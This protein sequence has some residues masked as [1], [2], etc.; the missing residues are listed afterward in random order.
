MTAIEAEANSAATRVSQPKFDSELVLVCAIS[1]LFTL[2]I[3]IAAHPPMADYPQ[4]LSMA[5]VLR[6][7]HDPARHLAETYTL[8][9]TRPNTAFAFLVVALSYL[10]PI[11]IA[12]KLVMAFSVAATGMAGLALARRAG[13]PGWFGLFALI[14]AYNC[15]YFFGFVNNVTATPL[16]LL[17]VVV[18]DRQLDRPI[19]WRSWLVLA[20]Y[21]C[22][23][24][25]VHLQFLFLFV[26]TVGWLTLTRRRDWRSWVWISSSQ[27]ATVTMTLLYYFLSHP[28]T[29]GYHEK[30]IY[31]DT[32]ASPLIF[33]KL[34]QI[35]EY[36]FGALADSKHW[37]LFGIAVLAVCLVVR[38]RLQAT[39]A[40]EEPTEQGRWKATTISLERSRFLS[41]SIWFFVAYLVMPHV[42]VGVFVYQRLIAVAWMML[43][44]V[45]PFPDPRKLGA[46]KLVLAGT[47]VLHMVINIDAA[48]IFQAE[49]R[50]GHAL[51]AKTSPGKN[52][53]AV[54][55]WM[56]SAGIQSPPLFVHFG[57]HYLA[58]KGGRVFFSF[59]ELY[60]SSVQLRPE[61]AFDDQDASMNEWQPLQFRFAD[62][63]YH[64]DYFLCHGNFD[65]LIPIFGRHIADLA[66]EAQDDWI[67]LWR[68]SQTDLGH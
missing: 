58:E 6:W 51:I 63:G 55:M 3:W 4:H 34:I 28:E 23:F 50:G 44:A 57:S 15:G 53:M 19:G 46:S 52:L 29:F 66:W 59:S 22:V 18:V 11:G 17:G 60:I 14:S 9:L 54:M 26:A 45:L 35:P 24:Y 2:P 41:L 47:I 37:L 65:R 30:N 10:I 56:G 12:G 16:F 48:T 36:L 21:G 27:I 38:S 5:S 32:H 20:S 64:Y 61:L 33:D 40:A 67:L 43:P 62:F 13:R 25:F 68:K 1:I 39:P 42:F 7:Y 8:A 31:S 49:T